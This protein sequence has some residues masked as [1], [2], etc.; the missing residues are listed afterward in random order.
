MRIQLLS[1]FISLFIMSCSKSENEGFLGEW[2]G[3]SITILNGNPVESDIEAKISDQGNLSRECEITVKGLTY[4]FDASE[5]LNLLT[6]TK[7][8]AKNIS[9]SLSQTYITGTAELIGD[10]LLTFDHQ[11]LT[12]DGTFVISVVDYNLE[13][14]RK[15]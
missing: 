13:F 14:K 10:T 15:E 8:P 1:I 9:D 11:V 2:D 5:G 12:M 4:N 7:A 3:K 6:F